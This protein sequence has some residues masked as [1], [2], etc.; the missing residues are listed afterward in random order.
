MS[1]SLLD[2]GREFLS[3]GSAESTSFPVSGVE[4]VYNAGV[5]PVLYVVVRP[6]ADLHFDRV[7]TIVDQEDDHRELEPD[8]LANLLRS[9]LKGSITHHQNDSPVRSPQRVP[10]R[11]RNRPADV[12]PLHFNLKPGTV[13]KPHV[14]PVEP[15]VSSLNTQG[16]IWIDY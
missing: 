7:T 11:C 10:K 16:S 6:V 1:E 14:E 13:G 9:E 8:H 2:G 12:A 4:H 5:I 3:I 15:G